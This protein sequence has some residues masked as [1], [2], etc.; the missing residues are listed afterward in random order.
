MLSSAT[1]ERESFVRV[2]QLLTFIDVH[3]QKRG[4][5]FLKSFFFANNDS[6]TRE[7]DST[8][9]KNLDL[10]NNKLNWIRASAEHQQRAVQYIRQFFQ[11]IENNRDL[12][13]IPTDTPRLPQKRVGITNPKIQTIKKALLGGLF[14]Y[15]T[16]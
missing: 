3:N 2:A 14:Y 9:A 7:L 16:W 5:V 11:S 4:I 10:Y 12:Q 6:L 1:D 8:S 13:P 15:R